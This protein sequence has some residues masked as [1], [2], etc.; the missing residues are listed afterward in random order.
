MFTSYFKL[1]QLKAQQKVFKYYRE[2]NFKK[3]SKSFIEKYGEDATNYL[4]DFGLTDYNGFAPKTVQSTEVNDVVQVPLLTIKAKGLSSLPSVEAVLKKMESGKSL[5]ISETL[6]SVPI[7]EYNNF[8][9][10]D[11]YKNS[12][13]K[14]ELLEIWIKDKEEVSIKTTRQMIK[15]QA[16]QSYSVLIGQ[17]WFDDAE[18]LDDYTKV[19]DIDGYTVQ[20]TASLTEETIEI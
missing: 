2:L 19:L 8:I 15:E 1:L 5:T 3:V 4:K 17:V 9:E 20:F 14:D 18:N 10:S 16:K 11:I 6:M 13:K 12:G 7:N